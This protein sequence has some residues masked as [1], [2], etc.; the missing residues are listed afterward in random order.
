[1]PSNQTRL[2]HHAAW[3]RW[4]HGGAPV[5]QNPSVDEELRLVYFGTGNAAPD[6]NGNLRSGKKPPEAQIS[7][8]EAA[9]RTGISVSTLHEWRRKKCFPEPKHY[10]RTLW[11]TDKQVL[12]LQNLKEFFRVYGKRPWNVKVDRLKEVVASI[13]ADWE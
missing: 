12:L 2:E 10:N 3:H 13:S 8:A 9:E 11:F 7:F 5:W 1:L 4:R 6:I